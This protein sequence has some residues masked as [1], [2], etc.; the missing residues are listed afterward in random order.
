LIPA[1]ESSITIHSLGLTFSFFAA[2]KNISG[3]GLVSFTSSL[4]TITSKNFSIS[5]YLNCFNALSFDAEVA[6]A[7]L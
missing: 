1:L 4:D 5:A 2:F 6:N 3:L 7:I